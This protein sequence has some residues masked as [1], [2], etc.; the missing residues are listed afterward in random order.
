MYVKVRCD[1]V[2]VM[3]PLLMSGYRSPF[4]G[5]SGADNP[6]ICGGLVLTNSETGCGA[7][8]LTPR[9]VAQVC[10][11]G[12][13]IS[14]VIRGHRRGVRH[15]GRWS[16]LPVHRSVADGMLPSHPRHG[17]PTVKLIW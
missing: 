1:A 8:A 17:K 13:T 7:C 4:T 6:F 16:V 9:M 5:A 2:A 15:G 10:R 11:N 3:A 12:M 14:D